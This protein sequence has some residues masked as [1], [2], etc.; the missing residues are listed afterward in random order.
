MFGNISKVLVIDN[1]K[2]DLDRI[3][4]VLYSINLPALSIH[5]SAANPPENPFSGIRLAFFDINLIDGRVNKIQIITSLVNAIKQYINIDN[6]PYVLIFWTSNKGLVDEIKVHINERELKTVPKPFIIECI[7]KTFGTGDPK[8]L[9]EILLQILSNNIIHLLF[10]YESKVSQAAGKTLKT[11][12]DVVSN[13]QDSWGESKG[14]EENFDLVFSNIACETYGFIHAKK[15]PTEAVRDGLNPILVNE[16]N[17]ITLSENWSAK[18]ENLLNTEEKYQFKKIGQ[19]YICQLNSIYH[20]NYNNV[21]NSKTDRG[22]VVEFNP[23]DELMESIFGKNIDQ[24]RNC[25]LPF[26][27][28]QI[29]K[30]DRN[31]IREGSIFVLLEI[32]SACDFAQDNHRNHSFILGLMAP[33]FDLHCTNHSNS[34]IRFPYFS[35][36]TQ[37]YILFFNSR[38]IMTIAYSKSDLL[39]NILFRIKNELLNKIITQHSNYISR[40]GLIQF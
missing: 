6:G 29:E 25:F 23:T 11:I 8:E 1:D 38:F 26:D 13:G 2:P 15:N 27:S 35:Y 36:K 7:D 14:F 34:I 31:R 19:Q 32:S 9:E 40:L 17:N 3:S 33:A 16:L 4:K 22:V 24:I 21:K 37:D 39:G 5:Y 10:D 28:K 12:F 30:K 20:I 18:L